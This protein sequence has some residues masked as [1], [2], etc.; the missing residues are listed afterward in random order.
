MKCI[1]CSKTCNVLGNH[2]IEHK[3]YVKEYY[4]KYLRKPKEGKCIICGKDTK[5]KTLKIGYIGK[6]CSPNCMYSDKKHFNTN[7]WKITRNE[8]IKQFEKEHQCIFAN[9]LRQK[10]G[11]G[12]YHNNIVKF[13]YMDSQTKFVAIN[14]VPKIIEYASIKRPHYSS[15][16]AEK[17]LVTF[18]KSFYNGI[19]LENL[20][21]II[22]PAELDIYLPNLGLAIEYNGCYYHSIE[23]G[24]QKEYHLNKSLKCRKK[25][26]RLIHIYEFENLEKQKKLLKDLIL[27]NDNYPKTDFNKNNFLDKIPKP[28]KIYK[29]GYTIYG[30]GRLEVN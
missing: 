2:L 24:T 8:K 3:L 7:A 10:Y 11:N 13:I 26:I 28:V 12:W 23:R 1:I 15:S 14:D 22:Y 16:H 20:R 29:N 21:K 6:Y 18:I 30:A 9:D 27:G 17:E 19:I 5:F 25:K 4:D